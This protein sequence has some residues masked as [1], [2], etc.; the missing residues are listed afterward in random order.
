MDEYDKKRRLEHGG[1]D[2]SRSSNDNR[3][4]YGSSGNNYRDDRKDDRYYRDDRSHYNNNNN[5][6]NN[7]NGY[8]DDRNYSSQNKY[9]NHHQ[10][11]PPQQQQ[12]QQQQQQNSSYIPS[13]PQ[14]QPQQPQQPQQQT[15]Q[16]HIQ[17]P[18]PAKPRKSRFDQAPEIIPIQAPQQQPPMISNQPIFKQQPMY[19][20]QK[21]QPIFQHHQQPIYQQPPVHQQQQP[22]FQQ[23]QQRVATEA[24]QF[25][26]N[27]QLLAIEQERLKQERENEKK[28]EQANLEEEMKKR[29]EK[30]EQWRKQKLE[31]ELK[32]SGSSNSG[33]TSS[34]PTIT[35]T[36]TTTTTTTK[37]TN[38]TATTS[39]LTIPS[40]QQTATTS[41]IKKKWSL[42]EEEE[43][44]QPLVNTNI[45]QKEIKLPPTANIPTTTTTTTAAT[46]TTT[47]M[48]TN[49]IKQSIEEDDDI[50][51]LDAY[52]ENLNKEA[53]LNLKKSKTS[54]MIDDDDGKLEEESEGEDDGKDKTIKK[55]KKEMLHTD[56]TSIKYAEF[57]KN[58]YIEVPV[59]ANMT[60]TEVLDFRSELGVKIT[61]K[62][63]P[64]PIQSWAQAGLTEKVHLLLKKFQ[65][66]KPTP[67]QAQTI[68]AIMNGRDLI[69]I[70]RTGSG[71]TLAFLL[72]MFRHILAQPKSAPGEGMIALIMSPTRELALQI[73]VECKKFSKVLGLRTAC[74]YGGASISE[75]IAELKR[76]A[77]IVVCTPGRM[78]DILCANNRRITNLRRVTFLVLD[79]ADRMFDMGFGPQ[80][81]CIVDSIR[82]DRQTIMF[83]A[84]FPPKV[85]N[86][87]KKILNKP[88]EIIAG[89]RSI[90]SSDIEQ[91]VEVRPTE[92]RFRRLIELLSIWYHKGQ[93]LIFTNRQETTD[94]LYRQLSNSQYQCLSLHGSKDQTDRDETISDFKNKVKT[95]LIATPLASRGLDIKDLNLVVNFDCPD[96]LEDYVHRVGRTG[97][98]GNRGTAYTFIT[99]DEERFSSSIIKALE[100]SASKV[101]DELRKLNDT[102]EKKRKEG[103]DVLLAPT[104][105]TGRGHKFDAAEED[106]KN[107]E[108][109]QQRKAYGIEEEEEEEDEDKEK[110][111]KEKLAAASSAEKEK[112]LLSEKEKLDPSN[113]TNTIVIP[114]VDATNITPSSLLQTD[115]SV[116]VG[117]QAINQIFGISQVT[118]SEEAIKKLQLAAQLGMK[119]NIQKLNNQITPLNQ[120]HFIEELE[121]N[122]Y[123]QQARWKVTHKDA[124]LEITNF[125]NTTIT[126]KGT[127]FPP[128]KIPAPGE[129]KLYLYIEGPSDA[130]VKNA[131]SDIKKILDEVQST[132]QSTG[133]YSVF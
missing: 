66:E 20:Q 64:K 50:D 42:E 85:E 91:F 97:R 74:V 34:P 21:Q 28:I 23:Q 40:Q 78:I 103:K 15:Q 129:R 121:I 98:A 16:P 5:N 126:T 110:A 73:H 56:H 128:N 76:G 99:P 46:T 6:N 132:H 2:R 60:E 86:V 130:S 119:G 32:A 45:E 79:E 62:D 93:I 113:T 41:P 69:G 3:N 36:T 123:S 127:F 77:D 48:N 55:G 102:Y 24:I 38:T 29:R 84:T 8:R 89:G 7:G 82:P 131:K 27:P 101:P 26:Q 116:P 54:Q 18:P 133:K 75:Q 61:G 70:A 51:P 30:V 104:G 31:L 96:H 114:G 52:M 14:S 53:N 118:S 120:T 1:S 81:N 35:T 83:S 100:Q 9:Q 49:T 106:K 68:P 111:E 58:F 95:I 63:C 107:I 117:Q 65:Y 11:S 109:K 105:F 17:A 72:P 94:N 71:K 92:T 10:Q 67:I 33:S 108:R 115:P 12:Q 59:L 25:Q 4:S 37:T 13:Q 124:L 112:Q 122:D 19:Q 22:I 57:Q 125:T 47:T 43:T 44:A 80:I 88:L 39:P 87:A 90:V